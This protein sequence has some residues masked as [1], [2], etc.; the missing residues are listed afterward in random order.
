MASQQPAGQVSRVLQEGCGE[1]RPPGHVQ[2]KAQHAR[3]QS[4][5]AKGR[6]EAILANDKGIAPQVVPTCSEGAYEDDGDLQ[7][8]RSIQG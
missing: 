2:C 7:S 1:Q 4:R 8:S 6:V 5:A 3:T